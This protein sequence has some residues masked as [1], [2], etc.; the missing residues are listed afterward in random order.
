MIGKRLRFRI[1]PHL[2]KKKL[3]KEIK[4]RN[5][6]QRCYEKMMAPIDDAVS[7]L[8]VYVLV[9]K[10]KQAAICV[11]REKKT[12]ESK[13]K[14]GVHRQRVLGVGRRGNSSTQRR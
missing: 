3:G 10:R 11:G 6:L 5:E 12:K 4:K 13:E 2:Q 1:F 9:P 14:S 8:F 7:A